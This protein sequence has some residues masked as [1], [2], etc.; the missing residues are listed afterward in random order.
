MELVKRPGL[1]QIK[2]LPTLYKTSK[3]KLPTKIGWRLKPLLKRKFKY[4]KRLYTAGSKPHITLFSEKAVQNFRELQVFDDYSKNFFEA[5]PFWITKHKH[6]RKYSK[7]AKTNLFD[8]R[9]ATRFAGIRHIERSVFLSQHIQQTSYLQLIFL[10][11]LATP[12]KRRL[13][14]HYI[15]FLTKHKNFKVRSFYLLNHPLRH[16]SKAEYAI[17]GKLNIQKKLLKKEDYLENTWEALPAVIDA[18]WEKYPNIDYSNEIIIASLIYNDYIV[19]FDT[20]YCIS[21]ERTLFELISVISEIMTLNNH[22]VLCIAL[23]LSAE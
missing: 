8:L 16:I 7:Q 13:A 5:A 22:I 15:Q 1:T 4:K 10:N 3:Y 2:Q 17:R 11:D 9:V 14:R 19:P 18:K 12:R 23:N 20:D 6:R 21:Y